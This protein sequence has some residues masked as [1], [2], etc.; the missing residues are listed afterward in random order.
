MYVNEGHSQKA[1]LLISI[2]EDCLPSSSV[3]DGMS[4]RTNDRHLS[5][6]WKC[7]FSPRTNDMTT[8]VIRRLSRR[9][10]C[11]PLYTYTSPSLQFSVTV[12]FLYFSTTSSFCLLPILLSLFVCLRRCENRYRSKGVVPL[13]LLWC[14]QR[15]RTKRRE[16]PKRA[17]ERDRS[18]S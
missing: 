13:L 2:N 6:A 1:R 8:L 16:I 14:R 11:P 10:T 3:I 4:T 18:E 12:L 7:N 17:R 9:W 5:K 15:R